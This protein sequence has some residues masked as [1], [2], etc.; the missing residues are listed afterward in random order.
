MNESGGLEDSQIG[1]TCPS[2]LNSKHRDSA[3]PPTLPEGSG[4]K[5]QNRKGS[6]PGVDDLLTTQI[7]EQ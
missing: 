6:S 7:Q 5:L 3:T 1:G 4:K 2:E